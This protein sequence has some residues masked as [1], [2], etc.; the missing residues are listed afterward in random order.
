MPGWAA[1][2]P[3]NPLANPNIDVGRPEHAQCVRR[4]SEYGTNFLNYP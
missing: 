2:E 3:L 4:T 1:A